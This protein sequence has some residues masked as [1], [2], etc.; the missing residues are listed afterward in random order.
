MY[1]QVQIGGKFS[2]GLTECRVCF[3]QVSENMM[4]EKNIKCLDCWRAEFESAYP[5][6]DSLQLWF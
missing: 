5:I 3:A 1:N 2:P 4:D 6:R